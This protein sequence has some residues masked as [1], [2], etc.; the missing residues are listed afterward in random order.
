[1]RHGDDIDFNARFISVQRNFS[2]GDTI[3]DVTNQ[4]GDD[5]MVVLKA[6][7]HRMPG[8]K[9]AEINALDDPEYIEGCPTVERQANSR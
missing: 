8:K 3:T 9:K 1:V 2:R 7:S 4:L 5:S 6:Y